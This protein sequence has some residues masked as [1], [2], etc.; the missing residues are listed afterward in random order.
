MAN[1]IDGIARSRS[2]TLLNKQNENS[3]HENLDATKNTSEDTLNL[4]GAD[5]IQQLSKSLAAEA[6]LDRSRIDSIKSAIS[7]GE[8][9]IDAERVTQK[10]SEL[11][12]MLGKL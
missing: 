11:E 9:Q 12:K 8:Y 6:P 7:S 3:K 4:T 1:T 2:T 10:F 5:S